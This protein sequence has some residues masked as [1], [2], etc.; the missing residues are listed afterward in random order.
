M[1]RRAFLTIGLVTAATQATALPFDRQWFTQGFP[2]RRQTRFG[3]Q[4]ERLTVESDA[5]VALVLRKLDP[6]LWG[7]R[8]ASWRWDVARSVPPTDLARKGGDDRNLALYFAFLPRAR[9]EAL[10]DAPP[11]RVLTDEAATTL[12]YVWGGMRDRGTFIQSPY[13]GA[14]GMT[15]VLR[16]AAPGS[17]SEEVDLAADHQRA[18]GTA[19]E[20]LFGIAVSADADDTGSAIAGNVSDLRLG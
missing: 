19:P 17:H 6:S 8:S 2:F 10:I 20:A 5:G 14:R 15:V 18:F 9:A 13:L 11:R 16:P 3:L 1:K 12:V 4:G 7:A